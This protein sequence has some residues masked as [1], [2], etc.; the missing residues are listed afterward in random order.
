MNEIGG[1]TGQKILEFDFSEGL[2]Y[3]NLPKSKK[4][5]ASLRP[6]WIP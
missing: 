2:F 5:I 3:A 6:P 1:P 4:C